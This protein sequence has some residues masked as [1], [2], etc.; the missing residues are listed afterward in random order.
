[1]KSPLLSFVLLLILGFGQISGHLACQAW[2]AAQGASVEREESTM[3]CHASKAPADAPA[4]QSGA[5]AS[6][7]DCCSGEHGACQHACHMVADMGDVASRLTM[8]VAERM[9]LPLVDRSL[10][11][12]LQPIDHIP[13]S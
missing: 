7:H 2:E 8:Q 1:M 11:L 9:L 10:S 4:L 13:L 5:P 12:N 6:G 3:R